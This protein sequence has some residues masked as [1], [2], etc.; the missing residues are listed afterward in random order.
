MKKTTTPS[1]R[2]KR[3][4][5]NEVD[6]KRHGGRTEVADTPGGPLPGEKSNRD[7]HQ[8]PDS[9]PPEADRTQVPSRTENL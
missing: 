5:H 1:P 3:P 2:Q 6:P 7:N 4:E 9:T 8:D